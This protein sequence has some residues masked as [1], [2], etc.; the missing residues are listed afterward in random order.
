MPKETSASSFKPYIPA[1][2]QLPEMTARALIMGVILGMIFGASSLYLV[3]KVGLTVSASIP[4]A[5]IAI[6]LF[7]LFNKFGGK[8]STILE[9]SITQ[10]AGSAG[11][12]LA[13]GLGVT[14]PAILILGFDLEISR[15]MLVG[16]LGG[17]LGI[18]MMIPMRRTMIVEKHGELKYPEGTAC[19]E[20]LKAAATDTSREAAGESSNPHAQDDANRRAKIIFAGF[21]IGLLYK[22]ANVAFKGWKDTPEVTFGAPLKAGSLGAEVSPELLGV[23]YIIG[24]RIAAVMAAGG[25]MSYLLLIPMIKFFGDALLTPLAPATKLISEMSPHDI[26]SAYILY[27]GAGA[28]AAGGL[29]SLIR[30]MPTIWR[31]LSAGLAGMRNGKSDAATTLRT[32]QDIPMKWVVIGALAIIAI[33]TFATPLH[34]NFLG[35]LLILVFGFLFVTVSSRLTGEIGSSSNPISGMTVATLLFT[36]LIFLLMGWTGGQYYVTALSVGAIVCIASS[37]GG[38]TSQDLKTGYLVGST[39]RLQQYAI[40]AGALSSALILGPILLKLNDAGTVYVPAAQVAPA[41][42]TDASKL[43]ETASLQGPQAEQDKASYKVWH[44]TDTVGGPAGKYLV[45]N[46]GKAVYLVDPGING[47]YNKR[48]DGTE[49]KKYDAPKAVLMSYIIKGI[50]DQQLPWTLVLFGVMIA[51]VLEMA[52]IPSLAFAVGVYLPLSSSAPLFIGGMIRWLVDRRNNKLDQYK[53]LNEEEMQAA[54]D[55]SSGVLLSSGYIAGG[56]L[57]G[58]VIAFTAGILTGFDK[59]IGDWATAHNPF[60]EG[61]YANG[62][63]L[64]PYAVIIVTL[65]L[66]A[67]EKNVK[68]S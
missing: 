33:I 55:R 9:N 32:D 39:P 40:L 48:P 38:T 65:Y 12:S 22:I 4:V 13:F 58:I 68:A 63:T 21:G 23:G 5:V 8:D 45:D 54:G 37:N 24:P 17:L 26:R 66:V 41:L 50:L 19:A 15:V 14:M 57:A 29:I 7:R 56:A 59:A 35:A 51:L 34:M 67:R 28:V 25:V 27:I 46:A 62:L 61:A 16:C 20:V 31:S 2:A 11:E 52:G 10:T 42:S 49:V 44:K 1:S 30:A 60:F 64:I 43:T 53:S 3:L 47:A 6:T 18:L 36:C